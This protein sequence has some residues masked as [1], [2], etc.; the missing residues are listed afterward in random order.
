MEAQPGHLW[1]IEKGTVTN[2]EGSLDMWGQRYPT[3]TYKLEEQKGRE[4]Q[5]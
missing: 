2:S 4:A 5:L 3:T 1:V